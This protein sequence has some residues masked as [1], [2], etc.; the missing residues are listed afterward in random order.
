M[1]DVLLDERGERAIAKL[2]ELQGSGD[3]EFSHGEADEALCSLLEEL[4]F[5]DVVAEWRK[6]PKWYG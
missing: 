1:E 4:N 3:P 6:V 2:K 5:G